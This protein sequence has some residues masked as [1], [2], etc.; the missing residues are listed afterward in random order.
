MPCSLVQPVLVGVPTLPRGPCEDWV[1]A[2]ASW[3]LSSQTVSQA[4][5]E[6]VGVSPP[7]F[8]GMTFKVGKSQQGQLQRCR[9][10]LDQFPVPRVVRIISQNASQV[11][12]Y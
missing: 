1:I 11:L 5:L 6:P 3:S 9:F 8:R 10:T 2:E 7:G 4:L 12:Q